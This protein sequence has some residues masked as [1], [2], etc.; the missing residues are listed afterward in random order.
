MQKRIDLG[1]V[2]A[3]AALSSIGLIMIF[4]TAGISTF[5][6][7]LTWLAASIATAVVFSKISP[8][9][10]STLAPFIYFGVILMLVLLLFTSDSYPKRWFKLGW[11]NLQP[12]EFAKFATILFLASIL[13]VKKRLKNFSDILIPLLIVSIPAALIFIEPDLGAAQIFYPILIL[14]LY[15]TGMPGVK[16]FIFFSPIISA[17]ASFSIYIWVLYFVGLAIF[18]YF[19][20]QL[21][22]FIYGLVS[23][24]L[25][26]LSMPIIWNSLKP[27]QQQRIISFFSP[28][29]DPKGMSWQTIQSKIAIG[30]GGI[31]GKGFLSGTQKRLEFLPER[32]TDFVFSC[33]GEEF[34]LV[35]I[36]L[37]TLVFGYLFYKILILTKETKNKFSSILASGILAWLSYQTFINIGMTLGLLPVTGVPLPFISY[38]GS[39]LLACFMAVGVCMA[40]SKSKF[41]Y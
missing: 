33:L 16:L 41:K 6:R 4:S 20:K 8:R 30:S 36:I 29:L 13:A 22:D 17:A 28:W 31:I 12:S 19:H 21:S 10:W 1:I 37:T 32:H 15:W 26:G 14:M 34:G 23:N 27:Y 5:T 2:V 7:Q 39:S 9:L 40:I 35:G 38:G 25:A 24:F 11:V 3:V 18:L